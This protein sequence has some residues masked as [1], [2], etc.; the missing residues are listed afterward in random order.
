MDIEISKWTQ[1][2][3]KLED[4]K[5]IFFKTSS[6]QS[7]ADEIAKEDFFYKWT[8][9]YFKFFPEQI[10]LAL[11]TEQKLCAYLTGCDNSAK[12]TSFYSSINPSYKVFSDQFEDYPCHLHINTHPRFIGKGIGSILIKYYINKLKK[13][14][15]KG[16]HIVTSPSARN[17]GFY[18]KHGFN[19]H[20]IRQWNGQDLLFMGVKF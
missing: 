17:T 7:F 6:V 1:N 11:N 5:E 16:L 3:N 18:K 12:A 15:K 2:K 14:S 10:L 20:I 13:Q 9:Y 4:F 19:D 8:N